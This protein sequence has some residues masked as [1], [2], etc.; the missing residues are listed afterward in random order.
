[1]RTSQV[2]RS[3]K[4][5]EVSKGHLGSSVRRAILPTMSSDLPFEKRRQS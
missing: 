4:S 3:A 1:M 2:L 5:R